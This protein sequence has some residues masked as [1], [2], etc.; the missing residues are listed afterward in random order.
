MDLLVLNGELS[1]LRKGQMS[2][3]RSEWS[4]RSR[5]VNLLEGCEYFL[6]LTLGFWYFWRKEI[7]KA[8]RDIN[9]G[10]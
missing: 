5:H 4:P 1:R 2:R 10:W 9:K 7:E 8:K 3:P 6:H